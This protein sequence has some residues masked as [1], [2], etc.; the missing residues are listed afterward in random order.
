MSQQIVNRPIPERL[1]PYRVVEEVG[2]GGL[3]RV[4]RGID[5]RTGRTVAIKVLHD[6][7]MTNRKFLG[8][9]HRELLIMSGMHHKHVVGYLDSHF[10]PPNCYIVT[11]FVEGWSG[12]AFMKQVG[13][14]PPL[15][16]LSIII[17]MMK[18]ID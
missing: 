7:Y 1:G 4:F 12:H 14:V 5:E 16:A 3:G 6:K 10:E 9:F 11:E 18:G 15:V 8:I 13:S 2:V 17:D